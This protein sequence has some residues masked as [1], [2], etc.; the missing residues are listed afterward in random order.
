MP[1]WEALAVESHYRTAVGVREALAAGDLSEALRAIDV[2][3]DAMSRS[4]RRA[5]RS[6][7]VRLMQH[8]LKWHG[9]PERRSPSWAATIVHARHEIWD[10]QE[11]TPSITEAVL[12]SMWDQCFERA[13]E[14][15]EHETRQRLH[16]THL[17]WH[18]V[19][20]AEYDL[21]EA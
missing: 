17:T 12:R 11:E 15:A 2:L 5:V 19:F 20:E 1:D 6:Q 3:I 14:Y 10:T 18:E 8:I 16:I 4:D 7:L 9:Q 13:K 21:S